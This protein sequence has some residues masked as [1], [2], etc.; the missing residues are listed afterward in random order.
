MSTNS[1]ILCLCDSEPPRSF[2]V[3]LL[4]GSDSTWWNYD[5]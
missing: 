3:V 5:G 1:S 2:R 4:R